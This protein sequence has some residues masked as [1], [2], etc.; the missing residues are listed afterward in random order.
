M[1][2]HRTPQHEPQAPMQ[3]GV[4]AMFGDLPE[5][6][7]HRNGDGTIMQVREPCYNLLGPGFYSDTW[8]DEGE[9]ITTGICPNHEMQPLNRAAG[10]RYFDWLQSLPA[11]KAPIT[12][13]DMTEAAFM[14]AKDPNYGA[15]SHRERCMAAQRLAIELKARRDMQ[16]NGGVAPYPVGGIV[17]VSRSNAPAMPNVRISDMNVRGP[18]M[19]GPSV[20]HDPAGRQSGGS[21]RITPA[22]GVPSGAPASSAAIAR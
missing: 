2:N 6:F 16:L 22:I 13:E 7:V 1:A 15:M 9:V 8:Y 4:A 10:Q 3:D 5:T 11:E 17:R 14:L 21:R 19:S 20:L 18:G 12:I